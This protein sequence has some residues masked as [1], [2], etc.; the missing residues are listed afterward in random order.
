MAERIEDLVVSQQQLLGDI[1][2]ELRSPLARLS[3][4]LDLARRRVGDNVPS[5]S[6]SSVKS[7]G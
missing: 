1:S 6:G 3:L 5:I 4:A 2:H 7:T